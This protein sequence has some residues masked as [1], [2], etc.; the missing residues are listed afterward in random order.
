M[1]RYRDISISYKLIGLFLVVGLVPLLFISGYV[2][3]TGSNALMQRSFEHLTSTREMK[4]SRIEEY[5]SDHFRTLDVLTDNVAIM[6]EE[7]MKRLKASMGTKK[8]QVENY[9]QN[10]MKQAEALR[11]NPFIVEAMMTYEAACDADIVANTKQQEGWQDLL[12]AKY[13]PYMAKLVTTNKWRDLLLVDPAG[14]IVFSFR[15]MNCG[16]QG[17]SAVTA[18]L[19]HPDHKLMFNAQNASSSDNVKLF[20]FAPSKL[21]HDAQTAIIKV[22]LRNSTGTHVGYLV[23]ALGTAPLNAIM[24][25]RA[26]LGDTGES[27]LIGRSNG[28]TSYRNDRI[29]KRSRFGQTRF[30]PAILKAL[31]G[32]AG[33]EIQVGSTGVIELVEYAPLITPGLDWVI[34]TTIDAQ[35]A[36][37]PRNSHGSDIFVNNADKNGYS[38]LYLVTTDGTIIYSAYKEMDFETNLLNGPYAKTNFSSLIRQTLISKRPGIIDFAPYAPSNNTYVAFMAQPIIFRGEMQLI[39]A[40]QLWIHDIDAIML[41]RSGL[42]ETGE[43]YLVGR[44]NGVESLRSTSSLKSSPFETVTNNLHATEALDGLTHTMGDQHNNSAREL[45][46]HTPLDIP[47]LNW[48]IITAISKSEIWNSTQ[49]LVNTILIIVA[50]LIVITIGLAVITSRPIVKP[51]IKL[52]QAASKIAAGDLSATITV[53]S[54]DEIGRVASTFNHMVQN[55]AQNTREMINAKNYTESIVTS[56]TDI[57]IVISTTGIIEKINRSDLLGYSESELIGRPIAVILGENNAFQYWLFDLLENDGN[58]KNVESKLY[59]NGSHTIAVIVSGSIITSETGVVNVNKSVVLV[60][61]DITDYKQAQR[62]L[63]QR[64]AQLFEAE[65]QA[66]QAK[67]QFLANMSH[68]IRT[69]M[70]AIIGLSGL[71]LDQDMPPKIRQYLYQI[72]I[73]A[74]S[75]LR[76]INDILDFSKMEAAVSVLLKILEV[77]VVD[78]E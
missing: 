25:E 50:L 51:L 43:T 30:S 49:E 19:L 31:D 38:D 58:I 41:D 59:T 57:L 67:S 29:V 2:I 1:F 66:H 13:A 18:K 77:T 32:K 28:I 72:D 76:I 44:F 46:S 47:S 8:N 20:D 14:N 7:G 55:L 60:A 16:A 36:I 23:V 64:D 9:L 15:N 35:E 54:N 39:V 12:A 42:G 37:V 56:M 34:L 3:T 53:H 69:P 68:E 48:A 45:V 61:K 27:Y 4:K 63:K 26:G 22:R 74:H 52:K 17:K 73:S 24:H 70:N 71:A 21:Y 75:L 65:R 10:N 40:V 6:Q 5:F 33:G 11:F 78:I 62:A